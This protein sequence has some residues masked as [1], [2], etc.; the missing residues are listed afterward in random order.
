MY[1]RT[2]FVDKPSPIARVRLIG[3]P[4]DYRHRIGLM[5]LV[6]CSHTREPCANQLVT[7]KNGPLLEKSLPTADQHLDSIRT[8]SDLSIERIV[9]MVFVVA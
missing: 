6:L 5:D 8:D 7:L 9:T 2:I 4:H 3:S 1:K